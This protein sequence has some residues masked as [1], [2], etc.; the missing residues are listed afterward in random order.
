MKEI[1]LDI[2]G[3]LL[4]DEKQISP[5]T[6][7]ALIQ[8]QENGVKVILASGRPSKGM[9]HLAH[10]LQM[11][12]HDGLVI[13]NNGAKVTDI[14][15]GEVLFNQALPIDLA[16]NVLEHLKGFD[17]IPMINDDEYMYVNDVF[18]PNGMI[19]FREKTSSIIQYES[20]GNGFLLQEREDLAAFA[21]FS[22]NKILIAAQADYLAEH[23]EAIYAPFKETLNGAFS[24]PFYFEITDKGI[25]KAKALDVVN[26]K[27]GIEAKDVIAFGDAH[28]DASIIQYAGVGVAMGNAHDDMKEMAD[29]VTLSNNED[30]IAHALEKF[31]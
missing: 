11:D 23:A 15:T 22:L 14:Q 19:T 21:D 29:F 13:S 8:A 5:K 7:E 24:A 17:V 6:K 18:A 31:L 9:F 26:K 28:N 25:D 20:R 3:T 10:E 1:V 2:D 12:K 16:K 4:S 27:L 30:G